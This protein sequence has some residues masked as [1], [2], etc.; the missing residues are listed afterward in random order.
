[1]KGLKTLSFGASISIAMATYNG[2]PHV[3]R[4]LASILD[5]VEA[6]DQLV[7]VDDGSS[8]GTWEYLQGL[9][10]PSLELVRNTV[11]QGIRSAFQTALQACRNEIIFLSDQDDIWLPNKRAAVLRAFLEEPNATIVISDARVIDENDCVTSRS[12]MA[13]RGGFR[14]SV[15]STIV[16]NRYLGCAMVL[17]RTALS[18][19]LPVP[20]GA[21]M[22]D[23]WLGVMGA[24]QGPV[25]YLDQPLL[26]Y[27]RHRRN[28]TPSTHQSLMQMIRWRVAFVA[29]IVVRVIGRRM[30]LTSS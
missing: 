8:D 21:P 4:Q 18:L 29:A 13:T 24:I 6:T 9:Q 28:A 12:F 7:V 26:D 22:H 17:R 23:M 27:R 14:G 20:R 3:R 2:L 16:K 11:N 25:I 10:H 5:Q 30:H 19:A 15:R 1:M